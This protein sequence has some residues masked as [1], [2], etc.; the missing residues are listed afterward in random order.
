MES[1]RRRGRPLKGEAAVSKAQVLN[2]TPVEHESLV[3]RAKANG[4]SVSVYVR[5]A[6][7]L[8]GVLPVLAL[9]F[10]LSGCF[11][12][13]HYPPAAPDAGCECATAADAGMCVCSDEVDAGA[14]AGPLCPWRENWILDSYLRN[15]NACAGGDGSCYRSALDEYCR[16]MQECGYVVTAH[17][18]SRPLCTP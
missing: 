6:L 12:Q 18:G 3:E 11:L 13:D 7:R 14:D 1:K 16:R 17:I 15:Q 9:V 8:I 10:F 2:L 5:G 4:Q